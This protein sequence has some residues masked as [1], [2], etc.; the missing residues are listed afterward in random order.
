[1]AE[2][3]WPP[4]PAIGSQHSGFEYA[5]QRYAAQ[6]QVATEAHKHHPAPAEKYKSEQ[7]HDFAVRLEVVK[8][9][10][11]VTKGSVTRAQAAAQF[12][13]TAA[14]AVGTVYT[15]LLGLLFKADAATIKLDPRALAPAVFLGG[16]VA[17]ATLYLAFLTRGERSDPITLADDWEINQVARV[18]GF[19]AWVGELVGRRSGLLR[20]AA[21]SL[22]V[23]V[24][25]LPVPFV[26]DTLLGPAHVLAL[27]LIGVAVVAAPVVIDG[28]RGRS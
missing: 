4:P 15:G 5:K 26:S 8:A 18:N 13:Q 17:L 19:V 21:L 20:C 3:G 24:T 1:M 28:V 14:A 12:V 22:A 23:A 7:A 6:L 9:Y 16:A 25:L 10:L 27:T 11:E 2:D